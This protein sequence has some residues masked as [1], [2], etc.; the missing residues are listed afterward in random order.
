MAEDRGA[1]FVEDEVVRIKPAQ[2]ILDLQSGKQVPYDIVSFNT[3]SEVPLSGVVSEGQKNIVPVKPVC[4]L[5][6]A[7]RF[8]LPP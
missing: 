5:L 7:Q 6:Q 3:G 2:R 4:N 8:I 1:T